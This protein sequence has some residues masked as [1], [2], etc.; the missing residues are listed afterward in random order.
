MK[1]AGTTLAISLFFIAYFHLQEHPAFPVTEMPLTALD[2]AIAPQPA[3]LLAYVS[4][5]VYVGVGPG[6]QRTVRD[7]LIYGLWM[8]ALCIAGLTVFYFWPTSV[9]PLALEA[10]ATGMLA[11]LKHVDAAGNAFPSMHVAGA[12]F[13][14]VRVGEILRRIRT[15]TWLRLTN[16]AWFLLIAWS[17]LAT[18]QHVALDVAG[19]ATLG[20]LFSL[21]SLRFRGKQRASAPPSGSP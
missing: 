15:P 18:K 17:T 2:L 5:W 4:L 12:T 16:L 19:G 3:A 8:I 20:L 14:M 21:A 10:P 11:M 7:A 6:L 9:P 13:T 1:A